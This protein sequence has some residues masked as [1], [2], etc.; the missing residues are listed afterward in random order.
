MIVRI[1]EQYC[2]ACTDKL[3][4]W[5]TKHCSILFSPNLQQLVHFLLRTVTVDHIWLSLLIILAFLLK[6]WIILFDIGKLLALK[7]YGYVEVMIYSNLG[8]AS[9]SRVGKP[10]V[11]LS[12]LT[13]FWKI[14]KS[15]IWRQVVFGR[16]ILIGLLEFHLTSQQWECVDRSF[17]NLCPIGQELSKRCYNPQKFKN[18]SHWSL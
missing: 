1:I 12:N 18:I 10:V 11:N 13:N 6:H 7:T 3:N 9:G 16:V 4:N 2:W 15:M 17:Q 8:Q 14:L 5:A